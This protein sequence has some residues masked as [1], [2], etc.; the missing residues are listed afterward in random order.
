VVEDVEEFPA[1]LEPDPLGD[2]GALQDR[3]V[4]IR[5][6]RSGMMLRAAPVSRLLTVT[7]APPTPAPLGSSTLPEIAAAT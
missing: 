1:E 6:A 4:Q 5:Q 3:K 7:V 2:C